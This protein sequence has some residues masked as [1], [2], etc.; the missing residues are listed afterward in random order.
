MSATVSDLQAQL[1]DEQR[2]AVTAGD[3]PIL[4]LAAAGTGK[5]RTLVHRVAHLVHR[6]VDPQ[7][8]LLLTFTNRAADEMLERAEA[9]VGAGVSGL[10][11]GTFHHMANRI[12][13]RYAP[14]LDFSADYT[15]LDR[16]DSVSILKEAVKDL[17][18]K[19]KEFPKPEVILALASGAVNR[20]DSVP[21][22]IR[23]RFAHHPVDPENVLRVLDVYA[24]RKRKLGAMDFDDLLLNGLRLFREHPDVLER[25]QEQFLHVLVDEYQDTNPIQA[26][27][28]DLIAARYRNLMVVGDDFQSIYSWRGADYRN[29]LTFPDRYPDARQVRL[30]T[31]YRSV[32][33]ILHVANRCIAGNPEQFQKTLRAVRADAGKPVLVQAYDGQNQARYVVEQIRRLRRS[34][35]ALKDMAVLY[36]AHYHAMDVQLTLA[37]ERVPHVVVSGVRFFEQAHVKDVCS[38]LRILHC[39]TDELAFARLLQLYP[40]VGPKGVARIWER[41]GGRCDLVAPEGRRALAGLLP[42]AVRPAWAAIEPILEAYRAES[43]FEDPGEVITRFVKTFYESY[44]ATA[45]DDPARRL[46]D[47]Q[48]LVLYTADFDSNEAFLSQMALITNL[49]AEAERLGQATSDTVRLTTVHQ[50]KGLEWRAVF[51]LW[52]AD[53]LFPSG[54]SL[55]ELGGESEERRLFYVAVT[56]AR[57]HLFLCVPQVRRQPDGSAMFLTPS[58]FVRE[59]D[60]ELLK[61]EKAAFF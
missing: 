34:G 35:V 1:N 38:L 47:L 6:P 21:D 27:W 24:S 7:R 59:L 12:L 52:L 17:K 9:L 61:P 30:E 36:R 32:P 37:R 43:L 49:D 26:E 48:E 3:G 33:G 25:F 39:P 45:F 14:R 56:R 28:V 54:R 22:T 15:I 8:I 42:P 40:G 46:E 51:V 13:R 11:G 2:A 58:R 5:T 60:A 53:G 57:D 44:A 4:V 19:T 29:I 18:L 50:A 10:W 41:L 23:D 20:R 55:D 16:D 31:N